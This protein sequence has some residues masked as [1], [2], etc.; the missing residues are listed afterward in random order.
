MKTLPALLAGLAVV[1]FAA[2]PAAAQSLAEVA[3]KEQER[4][5]KVTQPSKT[6]TNADLKAVPAP[7]PPAGGEAGTAP[8]ATQQVEQAAA[9]EKEA[10]EAAE[11][12][13]ADDPLKDEAHWRARITEAR[14]QLERSQVLRDALQSRINALTADFA[15]RDDPAQR[16]VIANDRQRALAELDRLVKQCEEQLQ[17]IAA[18]EEEARKAGVPPGWLR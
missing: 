3:R 18:I 10:G 6:Y 9:Q 13:E 15:A 1:V 12:V 14:D 16:A 7:V 2:G 8:P 11:A 4:R 5:T 17:A